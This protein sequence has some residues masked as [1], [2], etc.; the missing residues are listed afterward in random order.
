M[1][2][3]R[4]SIKLADL[5]ASVPGGLPIEWQGRTFSSGPLMIELDDAPE[6]PPAV[7]ILDYSQARAAV[8]FPVQIR[9]PDFAEI[10]EDL[11]VSTAFTEPIKGVIKSRGS[12][13]PD[14]RFALSGLS[15]FQPHALF[16]SDNLS[17]QVLQ[18]Y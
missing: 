7:G 18:G 2:Q 13:L 4:I 11:G 10:L 12:I 17:A 1:D 5:K 9:F 8:D 14:H 16:S 3:D 6:V 15:E